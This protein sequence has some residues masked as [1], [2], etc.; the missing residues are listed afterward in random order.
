[1]STGLHAV[2]ATGFIV[3]ESEESFTLTESVARLSRE[4]R[5]VYE[6]EREALLFDFFIFVR[7]GKSVPAR[8]KLLHEG[9]GIFFLCKHFGFIFIVF[10][11]LLCK[12]CFLFRAYS[13]HASISKEETSRPTRVS[14]IRTACM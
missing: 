14:Y 7:S 5:A 10:A 11:V 4:G 6:A 2:R 3:A 8:E 9:T 12:R 1:M 13:K